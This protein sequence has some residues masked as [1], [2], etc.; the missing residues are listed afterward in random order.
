MRVLPA[1]P[2]RST[3]CAED[4]QGGDSES[5][6]EEEQEMV[7]PHVVA[8][9]RHP[10]SSSVLVGAGRTLNGRDLRRVCN[11]VLWQTGFLNL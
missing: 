1:W 3:W 9:R 6:K 11:A 7:S 10:H 4:R 5:D 8:A 2:S